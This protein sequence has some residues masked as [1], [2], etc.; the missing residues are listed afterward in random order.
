MKK[1]LAVLMA[2]ALAVSAA[3]ACAEDAADEAASAEIVE[4][5]GEAAPEAALPFEGGAWLTAAA[6]GCEIYLPEGWTIAEESETGFTAMSADGAETVAVTVEALAGGA[7]LTVRD[8]GIGIEPEHHEKIFERFYRVDK[9]RSRA[10]GGTGL[11]LSIVKHVAAH[12][13]ASIGVDSEP[14]RGTEISVTFPAD[15]R[16]DA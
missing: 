5:A 7:R 3:A 15:P 13:R 2:L 9:S 11:G 8:T 16:D 1:Q 6:S 12:H 14:G 10:I 4:A